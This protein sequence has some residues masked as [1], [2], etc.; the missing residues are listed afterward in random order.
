MSKLSPLPYRDVVFQ[1]SAGAIHGRRWGKEGGQPVLALHGWLDNCA[2]FDSLA[3]LLSGVDLVA[4]DLLGHARSDFR[5]G[6]GPYNI[7]QDVHEIHAVISQLGWQQLALLGHSRGAMQSFIT[8]GSFPEKVTHL[9]CLDALWP[10]SVEPEKCPEQ[11]AKAVLANKTELLDRKSRYDSFDAGVVARCH[12]V[13][14]LAKNDAEILAKRGLIKVESSYYWRYDP[15]LLLPSEIMF[16]PR[17]IKAFLARIE[18]PILLLKASDGI[19]QKKLDFLAE[20]KQMGQI[21]DETI[22]GSHHFH[23]SQQ[24][25][26]IADRINRYFSTGH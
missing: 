9:A 21:Y 10:M 2:T 8:A 24:A 19:L 20:L 12:G 17:Q 1:T 16:T 15:C 23:L 7:W 6:D 11:L 22:D 18:V 4:I 5:R 26:A 13:F 3:P 25:P 14:R